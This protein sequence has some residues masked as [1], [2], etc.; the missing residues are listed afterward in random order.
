MNT[1]S[2]LIKILTLALV[3]LI[4]LPAF[5]QTQHGEKSFGIKGG[6]I[7]R[8]ESG[9]AGIEFQYSFS[10]HVR[11]APQVGIVFR[12]KDLDALTIDLDMHFP[13]SLGSDKAAFYPLLG[14]AFNS[15][16]RHGVGGIENNDDVSTHTNCYGLN[17]GLGFDFR[18]TDTFKLGIEGRYTL[19]KHY[20][21]TQVAISLAYVF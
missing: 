11:I 21:N 8:N 3:A 1:A 19:V 7:S 2:R 13:L 17:A 9:F 6:Y 5:A 16:T 14:L 18:L 20:P 15:W 4:A 10:S 12:H